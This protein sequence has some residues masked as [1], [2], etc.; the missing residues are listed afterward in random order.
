MLSYF[1][2]LMPLCVALLS[3]SILVWVFLV[4]FYFQ[5]E[6]FFVFCVNFASCMTSCFPLC[7]HLILLLRLNPSQPF[8]YVYI[9]ILPSYCEE[10]ISFHHLLFAYPNVGTQDERSQE[11]DYQ[12]VNLTK[13]YTL[14]EHLTNHKQCSVQRDKQLI[15]PVK[16]KL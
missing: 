6:F 11:A 9:Y 4:L 1:H 8:V 15:L 2:V 12:L 5:R 3:L 7:F 10:T 13:W 16:M 14:K